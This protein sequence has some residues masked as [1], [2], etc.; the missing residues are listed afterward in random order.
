M[1]VGELK[2]VM[3]GLPDFFEVRMGT[4]ASMFDHVEAANS[5]WDAK[6]LILYTNWVAGVFT[7][8]DANR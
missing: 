8:N 1:T 2:A 7:L 3:A 4:S 6:V 5:D